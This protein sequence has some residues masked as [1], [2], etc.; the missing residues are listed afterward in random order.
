MDLLLSRYFHLFAYPGFLLRGRRLRKPL[1]LP[2][3]VCARQGVDQAIGCHLRRGRSRLVT[4]IFSGRSQ[5]A[6]GINKAG[7]PPPEAANEL[8]QQRK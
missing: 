4:G 3:L 5:K 1:G 2:C 6:C 8:P 7:A